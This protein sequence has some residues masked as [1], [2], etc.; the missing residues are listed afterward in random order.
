MRDGVS[1]G[2]FELMGSTHSDAVLAALDPW[3]ARMA[4]HYGAS[5]L[6]HVFGKAPT[7]FWNPSGVWRQEIVLPINAGGY[8]H[9]MIDS[10]IVDVS[11]LDGLP[12][13]A[14]LRV[15]WGGREI[16]VFQTD[17]DFA[18]ACERECRIRFARVCHCLS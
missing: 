10:K 5:T 13:H 9:T 11:G 15:S 7:G 8:S 1:R 3:D 16:V 4:V 18:R 12:A 17:A 14:P 6:S 2:Q